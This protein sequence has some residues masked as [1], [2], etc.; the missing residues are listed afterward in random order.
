MEV[1]KDIQELKN[2]IKKMK[3]EVT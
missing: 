3:N 2:M 1:K